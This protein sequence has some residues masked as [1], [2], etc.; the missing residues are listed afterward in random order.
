M[1][2]LAF[3]FDCDVGRPLPLRSLS[4]EEPIF[5]IRENSETTCAVAD[6]LLNFNFSGRPCGKLREEGLS[7]GRR[8]SCPSEIHML[9]SH[10]LQMLARFT[11]LTVG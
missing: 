11:S 6:A 10:C 3:V 4:E 5:C 8:L 1:C 2:F 7:I 9:A